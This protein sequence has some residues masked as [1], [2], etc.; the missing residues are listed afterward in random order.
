M[1]LG[2]IPSRQ[3][4]IADSLLVA[5]DSRFADRS[6]PCDVDFSSTQSGMSNG[7]VAD[8]VAY[9]SARL[10][11]LFIVTNGSSGARHDN[12]SPLLYML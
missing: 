10:L 11:A 4:D 9:R 5:N 1:R 12:L 3:P 7:G 6:S 8:F 2:G